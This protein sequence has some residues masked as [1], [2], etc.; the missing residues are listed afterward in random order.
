[1]T[2]AHEVVYLTLMMQ[3]LNQSSIAMFCRQ[4]LHTFYEADRDVIYDLLKNEK[5]NWRG[6]QWMLTR[7]VY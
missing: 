3:W 4:S 6:L 5:L 2:L 7:A 1:M